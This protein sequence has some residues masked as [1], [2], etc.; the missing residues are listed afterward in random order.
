MEPKKF[1]DGEVIIK[2]VIYPNRNE[3]ALLY[4]LP[5]AQGDTNTEFFYL[6]M[7]GC[8]Q[9]TIIDEEGI[10]KEIK[11]N[12]ESNDRILKWP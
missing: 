9:F 7:E 4:L 8:V 11:V 10:E 1:A 6:V 5:N 3:Q 2:Q 12:P